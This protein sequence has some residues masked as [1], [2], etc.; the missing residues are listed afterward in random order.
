MATDYAIPVGGVSAQY[1]NIG[2]PSISQ[3]IQDA[4]GACMAVILGTAT[5]IISG[6][7]RK[8]ETGVPG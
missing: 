2:V 6:G 7:S 8:S 1:C 5:T 4:I 3:D